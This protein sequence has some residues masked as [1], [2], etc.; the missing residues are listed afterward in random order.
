VARPVLVQLRG[1]VLTTNERQVTILETDNFGKL[2]YIEV[3]A[4]CVGKIVQSHQAADFA[5]GDEKGYF[6]FGGSTVIVLGEPGR[7]QPEPD[8]V[9]QTANRRET[10][11]RLGAPV[12][13]VV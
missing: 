11:I 2:A 6:L 5:P 7:W 1:D 10:L 4:M 12:G 8:L 3:G 13:R 9:A